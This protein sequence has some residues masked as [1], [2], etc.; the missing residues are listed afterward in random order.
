MKIAIVDYGLSNLSCVRSAC[1][2]LGYGSTVVSEG[3]K[4]HAF[5]KVILPGVGAFG[6]AMRNLNDQGLT[7]A[8][9]ESVVGKGVPFLG[10]CLGAQLTCSESDEFGYS[11]GLGW[12]DAKVRAID[13]AHQILRVPHSGWDETQIKQSSPILKNI[14][15][16]SLFYFTHSHAIYDLN[17]DHAVS[18]CD[19]GTE[20]V[21]VMQKENIFATQFHPEKSQRMGLKLLDNFLRL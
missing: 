20:F 19:Y 15:E 3:G 8:L 2:R 17:E 7:D 9:N 12:F 6:D 10:I 18:V 5:D 1:H 16:D 4:L 21:A 13:T 11:K 14:D